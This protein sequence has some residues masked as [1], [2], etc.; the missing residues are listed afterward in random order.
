LTEAQKELLRKF[1]DS[2]SGGG[3]RHNPKA[4]TWFDGVREFFER[5]GA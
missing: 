2:V 3:A 4:R 1:D 5:M